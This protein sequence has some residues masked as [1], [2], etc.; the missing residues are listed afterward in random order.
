MSNIDASDALSMYDPAHHLR[1]AARALMKAGKLPTTLDGLTEAAMSPNSKHRGPCTL[2]GRSD[3][4]GPWWYRI[5][6]S[7][8]PTPPELHVECHMAWRVEAGRL[9]DGEW[10]LEA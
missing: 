2:C 6:N 4:P 10:N 5:E 8:L 1:V 9:R 3:F 7:N